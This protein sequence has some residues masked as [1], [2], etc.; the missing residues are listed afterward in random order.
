MQ[1]SH[2]NEIEGLGDRAVENLRQDGSIEQTRFMLPPS[3]LLP[4][5]Q[6]LQGFVWPK[7]QR[8]DLEGR[9]KSRFC[10]YHKDVGHWT[11]DCYR[12]R[13]PLNYLVKMGHLQEY[14]KEG[15]S[16][17]LQPLPY[18]SS[19]PVINAIL[20]GLRTPKTRGQPC[21]GIFVA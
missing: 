3:Q 14:V 9:D 1:T 21:L 4:I 8:G 20:S 17:S 2:H 7:P 11:N 5:I 18:T 19:R 12:L 10:E 16:N 6:S 13:R 15:A